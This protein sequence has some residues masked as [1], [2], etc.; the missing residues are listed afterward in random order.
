MTNSLVAEKH[1]S[2]TGYDASCTVNSWYKHLMLLKNGIF[3]YVTPC[4]SCKN[5]HFGGT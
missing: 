4:G 2:V 1:L 5:R 3:W